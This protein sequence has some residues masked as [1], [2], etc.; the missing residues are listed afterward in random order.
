MADSQNTLNTI[1]IEPRFNLGFH[2]INHEAPSNI[3]KWEVSEAEPADEH[4]CLTL[5]DAPPPPPSFTTSQLKEFQA[6]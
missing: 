6:T 1:I 5:F 4:R 3:M 2:K